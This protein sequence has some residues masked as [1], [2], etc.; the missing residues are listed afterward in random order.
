MVARRPK[1]IKILKGKQDQ[2][3]GKLKKII[4]CIAFLPLFYLL[5]ERVFLFPFEDSALSGY[6]DVK[7]VAVTSTTKVK[8]NS[9]PVVVIPSTFAPEQQRKALEAITQPFRVSDTSPVRCSMKGTRSIAGYNHLGMTNPVKTETKISLIRKIPRILHQQGTSRCVPLALYDHNEQWESRLSKDRDDGLNWSMYY[10]TEDAMTRFFRAVIA[11]QNEERKAKHSIPSRIG[12]EFPHIGQ[13]LRNCVE[14]GSFFKRIL[15]R[16]LC[17]YV[18]GGMYIDLE[19]ALPISYYDNVKTILRDSYDTALLWTTKKNMEQKRDQRKQNIRIGEAQINS[20][21]MAVSPGHPLM[22]Y[23]VQHVLLQITT[24]GYSGEHHKELS[25][26]DESIFV[27]DILKQ[28]LADFY[29]EQ[30]VQSNLEHFDTQSKVGID[31]FRSKNNVGTGNAT[32]QILDISHSV[33]EATIVSGIEFFRTYAHTKKKPTT[34]FGLGKIDRDRTNLG[35]PQ[36][37]SSSCLRLLF[38]DALMTT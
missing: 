7:R 9:L 35:Q 3:H 8:E 23:A 29:Q 19:Y 31:K 34:L 26:S 36:G 5:I 32:V 20:N 33:E 11:A 27:S 17:L 37:K 2:R 28:S 12:I 18:Y 24:L 22:Y 15:W 25:E 10:H 21:I 30:G 6:L 14:N 13:I 1:A 4:R 38:T 16:F